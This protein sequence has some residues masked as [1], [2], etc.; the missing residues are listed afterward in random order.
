MAV[1]R[2]A[3]ISFVHMYT[4]W[5]KPYRRHAETDEKQKSVGEKKQSV[6]R[7]FLDRERQE[8]GRGGLNGAPSGLGKARNTGRIWIQ[9]PR[10]NLQLC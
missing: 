10:G 2:V 9:G 4:Y 7:K 6:N 8:A 1:P 5:S 3:V